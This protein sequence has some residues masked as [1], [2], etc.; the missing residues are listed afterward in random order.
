MQHALRTSDQQT[1][2]SNLF[3]QQHTTQG[4]KQGQ[5]RRDSH[6]QEDKQG[7]LDVNY[8]LV[9]QDLVNLPLPRPRQ[10]QLSARENKSARK[11]VKGKGKGKRKGQG[12]TGSKVA[13]A[14][15]SF[16]ARVC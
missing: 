7:N 13:T 9:A 4:V 3:L 10:A 14:A 11:N 8:E 6:K 16:A 1:R 12:E 5:Q 2:T 15:I